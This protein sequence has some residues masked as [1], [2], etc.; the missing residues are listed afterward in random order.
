M[1]SSTTTSSLVRRRDS[2]GTTRATPEFPASLEAKWAF[3]LLLL[4]VT[5]FAYL[6]AW[7]GQP[8]WDDDAHMTKPDL[9]S[10][11]G[12]ARIWIE[13]GA[14]QQYYPLVHSF[15]WLEHKLWGDTVLPYHFVN[16]LLHVGSALLLF[17]ILRR[18]R[19]PGAWL[20]AA[21]SINF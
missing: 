10:L 2:K 7:N 4:I 14:T 20:A 19:I 8:I 15:F 16:I 9:R 1:R 3:A 18:L 5:A 13:P 11:A 21:A 12:L 17:S 6:P